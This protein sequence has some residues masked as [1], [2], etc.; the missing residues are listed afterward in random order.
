M[1]SKFINKCQTNSGVW[2]TFLTFVWFFTSQIYLRA[3][4]YTVQ[5]FFVLIKKLHATILL[6]K[7]SNLLHWPW[8]CQFTQVIEYQARQLESFQPQESVVAA[9]NTVVNVVNAVLCG[10]YDRTKIAIVMFSMSAV[11]FFFTTYI[12]VDYF[13]KIN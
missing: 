13:W 5:I 10:I 1:F 4:F 11:F 6:L 3:I 12:I 7:W 8:F 9:S 2:P